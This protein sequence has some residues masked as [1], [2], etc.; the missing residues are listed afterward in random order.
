MILHVSYTAESDGVLR[1]HVEDQ[2]AALVGA[3]SQVLSSTALP[4]AFSFRQEI[5]AA[6]HMLRTNP[7]GA[8]VTVPITPTALPLPMQG[9]AVT[10]DRAML[11]LKLA[12]GASAMG[13]DI[14]LN[15]TALTG[16][17][18]LPDFPGY[19]GASAASAM[20]AGLVNDHTIAVTAAGGLAPT[21]ASET[22]AIGDGLLEDIVLYVEVSLS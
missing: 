12:D 17:V 6:F 11:L 18:A 14:N 2:N 1:Q 19:V 15:G 21:N 5:S 9:P 20:A 8:V 4:R 16:F 7:V 22:A 10:I 13:V 3:L